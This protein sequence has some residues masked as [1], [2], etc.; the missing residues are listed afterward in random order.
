MNDS[1]P[2]EWQHLV[3]DFWKKTTDQQQQQQHQQDIPPLDSVIENA[4]NQKQE[5][6]LILT[7]LPTFSSLL[8][9]STD[10]QPGF[11]S[12][13]AVDSLSVLQPQLEEPSTQQHIF[14]QDQPLSSFVAP[15]QQQHNILTLPVN[16]L[17]AEE[18]QL[19]QPNELIN[20]TSN[21]QLSIF[22]PATTQNGNN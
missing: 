5:N 2:N 19:L 6:N 9:G 3:D 1:L 7:K 11:L 4:I 20:V 8:S 14:Q 15:S 17:S 16:S 12:P 21:F 13:P 18:N 22:S 10:I